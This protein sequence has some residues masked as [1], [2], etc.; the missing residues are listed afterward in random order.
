MPKDKIRKYSQPNQPRNK[1]NYATIL[2]APDD[3]PGSGVPAYRVGATF[4]KSE[5]QQTLGIGGFPTG[6][7]IKITTRKK[8]FEVKNKKAFEITDW[9]YEL[10]KT[11]FLLK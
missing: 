10:T 3:P 1:N 9:D 7:I 11:E 2:F 4:G 5:Y 6:T 8:V